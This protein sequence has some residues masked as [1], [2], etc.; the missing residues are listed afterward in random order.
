[1]YEIQVL[2][3]FYGC[4]SPGHTAGYNKV[5]CQPGDYKLRWPL[6][7][8]PQEFMLVCRS[9]VRMYYVVSA[10]C[11]TLQLRV[12]QRLVFNERAEFHVKR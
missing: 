11:L 4:K 10:L 6:T 12:I 9:Y 8:L 1:M 2:L 5:G 3:L 7:G